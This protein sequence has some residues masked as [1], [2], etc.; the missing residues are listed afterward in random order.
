MSVSIYSSFLYI[1]KRFSDI[2]ESK[3]RGFNIIDVVFDIRIFLS[4]IC[5]SKFKFLIKKN[6]KFVAETYV[7][8]FVDIRQC[9]L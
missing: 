1:R 9:N 7:S 8:V 3:R 4:L 2:K 6:I 5:L